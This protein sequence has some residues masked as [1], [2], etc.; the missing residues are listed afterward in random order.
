M[1]YQH[2]VSY[3]VKC[4]RLCVFI[5]LFGHPTSTIEMHRIARREISEKGEPKLNQIVAFSSLFG[6][7]GDDRVIRHF[8]NLTECHAPEKTATPLL[9]AFG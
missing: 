6:G 9:L 3:A 4:L 2:Y 8:Q 7:G 5:Y 1:P